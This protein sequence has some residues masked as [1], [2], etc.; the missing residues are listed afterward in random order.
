MGVF[1]GILPFKIV[2]IGLMNSFTCYCVFC[3]CYWADELFS[4]Q[5]HFGRPLTCRILSFFF[6]GAA[7]D[8]FQL[9]VWSGVGADG[10]NLTYDFSLLAANLLAANL[11]PNFLNVSTIG[12]HS[13]SIQRSL[14]DHSES[15][16]DNTHFTGG[17]HPCP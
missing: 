10:K 12:A 1:N 2:F 3:Y 9:V 11:Q 4:F 13:E 6:F 14:K 8:W 16:K 7:A 5:L 17:A 15:A